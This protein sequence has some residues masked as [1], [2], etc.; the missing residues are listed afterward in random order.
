MTLV[1]AQSKISRNTFYRMIKRHR[2]P[3]AHRADGI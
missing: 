3:I 2:I 1:A